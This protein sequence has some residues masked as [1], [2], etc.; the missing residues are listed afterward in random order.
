[1][2]WQSGVVGRHPLTPELNKQRRF[3]INHHNS[4]EW[5][6]DG[7]W[8]YWVITALMT[9]HESYKIRALHCCRALN[10]SSGTAKRPQSWATFEGFFFC[11][12]TTLFANRWCLIIHAVKGWSSLWRSVVQSPSTSWE[13]VS[14]MQASAQ[15]QAGISPNA[16]DITAKSMPSSKAFNSYRSVLQTQWFLADPACCDPCSGWCWHC[17][18]KC[19]FVC[20]CICLGWWKKS[21]FSLCKSFFNPNWFQ[22]TNLRGRIWYF[23][24]EERCWV[25]HVDTATHPSPRPP[26]VVQILVGVQD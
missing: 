20:V 7:S 24:T 16:P 14:W 18:C 26:S 23:I 10:P 2:W 4:L 25:S 13:S 9:G 11:Q 3:G 19:V 1:M 21:N 22:K 5:M 12:R 17:M 8:S 15:R 6:T